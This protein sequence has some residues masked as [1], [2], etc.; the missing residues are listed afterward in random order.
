MR[1]FAVMQ[2]ACGCQD[3]ACSAREPQQHRG[4]GKRCDFLACLAA[5]AGALQVRRQCSARRRVQPCGPVSRCACVCWCSCSP[6]QCRT[7]VVHRRHRQADAIPS[8]AC[9]AGSV[10]VRRMNQA[11][12]IRTVCQQH[13][14]QLGF[15]CGCELAECPGQ[16]LCA[17][18]NLRVQ[19]A[20]W[21]VGEAV[22]RAANTR[23]KATVKS[24]S[25]VMLSV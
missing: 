9:Q 5:G 10:M 17:H 22:R 13:R 21:R 1:E 15:G 14:Q 12:G 3:R 18:G 6:P 25:L 19:A 20:C 23:A 11:I 7:S 4:D 2:Q 24:H 8:L 16:C